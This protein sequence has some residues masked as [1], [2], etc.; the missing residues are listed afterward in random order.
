MVG[1]E[2]FLTLW[3]GIGG[4]WRCGGGGG[5][6][7]WDAGGVGGLLGEGISWVCTYGGDVR[8]WWRAFGM[9]DAYAMR[10]DESIA[11]GFELVRWGVEV[12]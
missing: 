11:R 1:S 5:V 10:V 4:G 9:V 2:S 8:C 12:K 7:F 3:I 6:V